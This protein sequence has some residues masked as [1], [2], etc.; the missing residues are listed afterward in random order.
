M[1]IGKTSDNLRP[2][3]ALLSL[4]GAEPGPLLH[5]ESGAPLSKFKFVEHVRLYSSHGVG[6]PAIQTLGRWESSPYKR[7][8]Q[9][10]PP[11]SGIIVTN[12]GPMPN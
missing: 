2:V 11:L 3:T 10:D 6:R 5:W 7:Y 12:S 8:I 9:Q 1:F 4:R